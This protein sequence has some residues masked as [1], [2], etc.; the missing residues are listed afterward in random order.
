MAGLEARL[1]NAWLPLFSV[2]SPHSLDAMGNKLNALRPLGLGRLLGSLCSGPRH[3]P[4]LLHL[5]S[6]ELLEHSL[7][8]IQKLLLLPLLHIEVDPLLLLLHLP[9]GFK[10]LFRHAH[11]VTLCLFSETLLLSSTLESDLFLELFGLLQLLFLGQG[12]ASLL[13]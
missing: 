9:L 5:V 11:T 1:R 2:Q 12:A 10:Q 7:L 4:K 3:M 13:L 8:G 6:L